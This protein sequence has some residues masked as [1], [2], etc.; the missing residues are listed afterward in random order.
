M[1]HDANHTH[2]PNCGHTAVR[3]GDHVDYLVDGVLHH[4]TEQGC[5]EH[6]LDGPTECTSGHTCAG[7]DPGH[8]HGPG[9][10]HEAVKHG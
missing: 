10:G 2:G 7:H 5:V 9:C 1:S 8:R 4:P 6:V 3:H